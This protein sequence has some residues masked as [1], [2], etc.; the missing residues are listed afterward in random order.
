M[1]SLNPAIHAGDDPT[2][3]SYFGLSGFE[4]SQLFFLLSLPTG[5][6]SILA[7]EAIGPVDTIIVGV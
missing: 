3:S 7:G 2:A 5:E 1:C 6:E 4:G